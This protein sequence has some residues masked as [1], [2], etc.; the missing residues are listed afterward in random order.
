VPRQHGAG[1]LP[2]SSDHL[3]IAC[4]DGAGAKVYGEVTSVGGTSMNGLGRKQPDGR[5]IVDLRQRKG[6]M[7]KNLAH[8]AK[9]SERLLR[10]IET[11]NHPV[12]ATTITNIATAL[13]TTP[14]EITLFSTPDGTPDLLKLTAIRSA[15]DLSALTS[16]ATGFEWKVEAD[17]SPVTA[18]DMQTLLMIVERLVKL[19]RDEFDKEPFGEIPRLARLQQLLDQLREQGVGV[20][21]GKYGRHSLVSTLDQDR[22]VTPLTPIPGKPK[23]S[24]NTYFILCLHLVPAEKQE[25]DIQIKPGKSLD[26][27]LEAARHLP[28]DGQY[29]NREHFTEIFAIEHGHYN[30]NAWHG[31]Y[32]TRSGAFFKI[33]V[34][35]DGETVL[36]FEPIS[37]AE[38]QKLTEKYLTP[39]FEDVMDRNE[40]V[41]EDSTFGEYYTLINCDSGQFYGPYETRDEAWDRA[42]DF[43]FER[44]EIID[45]AG[46]LQGQSPEQRARN[47]AERELSAKRRNEVAKVMHRRVF[48]EQTPGSP[49][50]TEGQFKCRFRELLKQSEGR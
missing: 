7:Q 12:P 41:F 37:D 50:E 9:I 32:Q 15:K 28:D 10:D 34:N 3:P 40:E 45:D 46:N 35:H 25:G 13:Q 36:K 38:A 33:V 18:K 8:E 16:G 23:W 2:V 14:D 21:A 4:R 39:N 30:S 49:L 31:L 22:F 19:G 44:Y 42:D 1:A 24:I 26:H 43:G 5:K 17:P 20:I 6:L 48:P 11:K 27:L 47:S 29:Y